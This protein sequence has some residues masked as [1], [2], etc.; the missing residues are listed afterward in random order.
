[1]KKVVFP[2]LFLP[3]IPVKITNK[4]AYCQLFR[5]TEMNYK[6]ARGYP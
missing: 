2:K 6:I 3:T 4:K 1:M 5:A